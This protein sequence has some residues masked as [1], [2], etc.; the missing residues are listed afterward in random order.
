M[1][2]TDGLIEAMDPKG[3][4]FEIERVMSQISAS[5]A[6]EPDACLRRIFDDVVCFAA[7]ATWNNDLTMVIGGR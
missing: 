3:E 7:G 4:L 6:L 1:L 5:R 2:F